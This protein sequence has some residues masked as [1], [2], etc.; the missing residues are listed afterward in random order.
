[1]TGGGGKRRQVIASNFCRPLC[2]IFFLLLCLFSLL[3]LHALLRFGFQFQLAACLKGSIQH[4]SV[5]FVT[6]AYV[7]L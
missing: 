5:A 2:L 1:M 7:N 4:F 6:V 3:F